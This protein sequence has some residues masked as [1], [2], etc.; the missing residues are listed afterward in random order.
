MNVIRDPRFKQLI[1]HAQVLHVKRGLNRVYLTPDHK[2]YK[3]F[4]VKD[5]Y[6]RAQQQA[7]K[8]V[9][10]AKRLKNCS[11][12]SIKVESVVEYP[13]YDAVVVQYPFIAG[14]TIREL[15]SQTRDPYWLTLAYQVM[16]T[17]QKKKIFFEDFNP[18]NILLTEKEEF[19]LIDIQSVRFYKFNLSIA[20]KCKNF[21]SFFTCCENNGI[22]TD[23]IISSVISEYLQKAQFG[24]WKKKRFYKKFNQLM[25]AH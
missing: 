25:I 1:E 11:V 5:R 8:F 19:V 21:V 14:K 9:R 4:Y 22:F 15:Y 12:R 13:Q 16:L 23:E 10:N 2:V 7:N 6:H 20:R 18:G 17:I 24:S 3:V